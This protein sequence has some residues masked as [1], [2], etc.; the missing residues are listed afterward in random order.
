MAFPLAFNDAYTTVQDVPLII[1]ASAGVLANDSDP[2]NPGGT[3]DSA[4][5]GT[6]PSNGTVVLNNDGSFRYTPNAGFFGRDSFTYFSRD[7]DRDASNLATVELTVEA[8]DMN[9]APAASD[10]AYTTSD[11]TPLI[12]AAAGVLAND[13]DVDGT[14]VEAVV[15][16]GPGNGTLA[17]NANGS[18]SY[19][20]FSGFS[21]SDSFTYR[22]RDNSGDLSGVATVALT[23]E[24]DDNDAPVA[25]RDEYTTDE[26]TPL[27]INA[28]AGVLANDTDSDGTVEFAILGYQDLFVGTFDFNADG[29]FTY[30]PAANFNESFSFTYVVRDDDGAQ[31][32]FAFVSIDV[33][34]VDDGN[35]VPEARDDDFRTDKNRTLVVD[36]E[37]SGDRQGILNNDFDFDPDDEFGFESLSAVLETGPSNGTLVIDEELF[38]LFG[39]FRYTPNPD[40]VGVDSFTYR[41][42]DEEGALSEPATVTIEVTEPNIAPVA[43]DDAYTVVENA[44]LVVSVADGLLGNDTDSDGT[45]DR[46]VVNAAVRLDNGRITFSGQDGSFVYIPDEGFVGV[47]QFTYRVIDNDETSSALATVVITVEGADDPDACPKV[48]LTDPSETVNFTGDHLTI[49]NFDAKVGLEPTSDTLTL[50]LGGRSFSINTVQ[51]LYNFVK[52]IEKDGRGATDAVYDTEGNLGLILSRNPDGTVKDGIVFDGVIGRDGITEAKLKG[53]FADAINMFD[54]ESD[55]LCGYFADD[56]LLVA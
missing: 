40:F 17:L 37:D 9:V 23:V 15:E 33:E 6:L 3:V 46:A 21:G 31:S 43:N 19:T 56:M 25:N 7:N 41:A 42:R 16:T 34:P 14:V 8:D 50:S 2:F 52:F 54:D 44:A 32:A 29:S 18:F 39:L 22:A 4:I 48:T 36:F 10:D 47:E 30:T 53:N 13:T 12:I 27:V 26:D 5:L 1:T 35:F 51:Q 49:V 45:V 24:L 38:T 20:P 11:D 28:A 55:A